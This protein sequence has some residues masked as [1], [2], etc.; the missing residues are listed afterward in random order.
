[1]QLYQQRVTEKAIE[2]HRMS[3]DIEIEIVNR[4]RVKERDR[5]S[6]SKT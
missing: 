4:E 1:M 3:K 5:L 2:S 6:E